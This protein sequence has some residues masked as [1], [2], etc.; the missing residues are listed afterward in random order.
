VETESKE[1]SAIG[2]S[3]KDS[4]DGSSEEELWCLEAPQRATRQ[5]LCLQEAGEDPISW[6][7]HLSP[8]SLTQPTPS[9]LLDIVS[10]I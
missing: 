6:E 1:S 2:D 5:D 4:T 7:Q 9:R 3:S 10:T 8:S